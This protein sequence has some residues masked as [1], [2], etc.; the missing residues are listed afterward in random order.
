MK[1]RLA[2]LLI[3][4]CVISLAGC[5]DSKTEPAAPTAAA[6]T[7]EETKEPAPKPQDDPKPAEGA[8]KLKIQ[9][10]PTQKPQDDPKPAEEGEMTVVGADTLGYIS[11]PSNWTEMKGDLLQYKEP[12]TNSVLTLNHVLKT[13]MPEEQRKNV[14]VQLFVDSVKASLEKGGITNIKQTSATVNGITC[15]KLCGDY[16]GH[17]MACWFIDTDDVL[18]VPSVEGPEKEIERLESYVES[19][20]TT[21]KPE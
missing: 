17:K 9:T 14:T 15:Q 6:Q 13:E 19:S 8:E 1:K 11:I 10:E 5:K 21:E 16:P 7:A 2:A 4:L 3:A 18:Y 20:F 12:V